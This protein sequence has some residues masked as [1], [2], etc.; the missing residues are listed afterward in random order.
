MKNILKGVTCLFLLLCLCGCEQKGSETESQKNSA[1]ES[2]DIKP[3]TPQPSP[4]KKPSTKESP[5]TSKNPYENK[6]KKTC[7]VCKGSGRAAF[8]A[9]TYEWEEPYYG[10]C[11]MCDSKG[12]YW[13]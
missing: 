5:V 1:V 8:Y 3:Q 7:I 10:P 13:E 2:V 11:S 12:Y 6:T 4:T 9:T